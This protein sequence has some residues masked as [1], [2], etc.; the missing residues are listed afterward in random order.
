MHD[1]AVYED[2]HVFRPERFI[3]DGKLRVDP[4]VRDPLS[5]VFGFGRRFVRTMS[6]LPTREQN[7]L[8]DH[9]ICP[10]R[11]FAEASLF[12]HVASALHVF[13]ITPALDVNGRPIPIEH[14]QTPGFVSYVLSHLLLEYRSPRE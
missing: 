13:D 10:G 4:S 7:S 14:S 11:H 2:Q 1:P 8:V 5:F 12:I 3:R 9:R 6:Y